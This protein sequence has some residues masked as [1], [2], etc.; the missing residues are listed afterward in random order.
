[1][2]RNCELSIAADAKSDALKLALSLLLSGLIIG[3]G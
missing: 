2:Q 1:M 3:P